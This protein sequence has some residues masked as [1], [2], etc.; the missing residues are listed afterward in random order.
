V[1]LLTHHRGLDYDAVLDAAPRLL[2][3]TGRLRN[4]TDAVDAGR[5]VLL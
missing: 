3:A 1:V 2:D 5:L 4:R